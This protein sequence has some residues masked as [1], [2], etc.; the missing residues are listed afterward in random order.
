MR[1]PKPE[2]RIKDPELLAY[3]RLK[4]AGEPCDECELRP[5]IHPHHK[6]FRSQR[7]DDLEDNLA[8]LCQICHDAAHGIRSF[9]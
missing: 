5:G 7:G 3:F 6:K 9:L 2:K 4:N 8:W 1:D